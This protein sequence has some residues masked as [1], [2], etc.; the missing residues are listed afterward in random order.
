VQDQIYIRKASIITDMGVRRGETG[1]CL[2]LENGTRNQ[3]FLENLT[4]AAWF[5]LIYLF[6]AMTVYLLVWHS[7]CTRA[8]FTALASCS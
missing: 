4:S 8:R 7:H 2:P 5:E 1:I 3:K 6:L